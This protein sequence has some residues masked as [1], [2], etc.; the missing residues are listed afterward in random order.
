MR[1]DLISKQKSALPINYDAARKL[2]ALYR[3]AA[4][5]MRRSYPE[6]SVFDSTKQQWYDCLDTI[7]MFFQSESSKFDAEAFMAV[8]GGY[9]FDAYS[10]LEG[11]VTKQGK[12]DEM[13]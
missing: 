6:N 7:T 12:T 4:L 9:P 13:S 5:A 2:D 3:A 11:R 10:Y 8:A 1:K